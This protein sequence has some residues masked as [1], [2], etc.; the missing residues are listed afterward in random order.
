MTNSEVNKKQRDS[1]NKDQKKKKKNKDLN[2]SEEV[3]FSISKTFLYY[4]AKLN[5]RD[6][7]VP[8]DMLFI[9]ILLSFKLKCK[10]YK[11]Y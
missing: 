3:N 9:I 4:E 2:N 10:K 5:I 8:I 7:C 11:K 1:L 6:I